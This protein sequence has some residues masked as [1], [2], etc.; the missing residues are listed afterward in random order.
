M[1]TVRR[2]ATR[3]HANHGWLDSHH[4]FSFANYHDP[5]YMGFGTLRVINDDRVAPGRGFGTHPHK[6]MEI[7]S[8]VVEGSLEHKD[9]MGTGSVIQAGDVQVMSAGTGVSHSEFNHSAELGVHFLQI[10]VLPNQ[11]AL[12]PR[13]Q[14]KF[15]G[16]ERA[17]TLRLV[18]SEDGAEGSLIVNQDVRLYASLLS[19]GMP[20]R[21]AIQPARKVYVQV[22]S[23]LL[24][25]AGET[26]TEG[27]GLEL[28][29][30]SEVSLV[31]GSDAHFLLF[32]LAA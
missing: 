6:D 27:D 30:E 22:I 14:Q 24:E 5:A 1:K 32:D 4:T 26:L 9:S 17:N 21:H 2:A 13:Y 23:G 7:I 11:R 29:E 8:Y 3:G 19:A 16:Q 25:V 15:F 12:K 10:W 20:V 28:V 31:A 18:A